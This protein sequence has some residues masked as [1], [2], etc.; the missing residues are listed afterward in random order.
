MTGQ[1]GAAGPT[2]RSGSAGPSEPE[3]LA[4]AYLSRVAEPGSIPLWLLVRKFGYVAAAAA[5]RA[6]EVS[7]EVASCTEARRESADPEVDL[8]AAERNGIRLLMPSSP[9]WPHFGLGSMERLAR[10]RC[11]EWLTGRAD[12]FGCGGADTALGAVGPR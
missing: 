11:A 8:A 6:G 5:V 12:A 7:P 3:L 1:L 2:D 9:D 10:R 4:A